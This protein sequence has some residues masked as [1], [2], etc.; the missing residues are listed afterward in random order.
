MTDIV[1]RLRDEAASSFDDPSLRAV[2]VE[3]ATE[4]ETLREQLSTTAISEWIYSRK[5]LVDEIATLRAE[6]AK[7]PMSPAQLQDR[8]ET[9][10]ALLDCADEVA[11]LQ[12]HRTALRA[13]ISFLASV[14]R[15]GE[16]FTPEVE[17][18][19]LNAYERLS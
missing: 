15:A 19:V 1:E 5:Q 2:L 4:I 17:Q 12:S 18:A 6:L 9:R 3:A 13:T 8:A 11:K 10:Q 16:P 7:F 14:I